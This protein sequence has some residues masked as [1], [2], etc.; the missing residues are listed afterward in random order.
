[1]RVVGSHASLEFRADAYNLFNLTNRTSAD[2]L[3]HCEAEGIGFIPWFPVASGALS[4]LD[5]PVGAVVAETGATPTQV[6]LAWLLHHS[7]V[8]L[9]I[10][11]TKSVDHVEE[12]CEAATLQ[13]SE[14]QVSV[15][16]A[17]H[18]AA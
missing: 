17:I 6:A 3:A 2:V 8:M 10:P 11:G 16:D 1:M 9:P 5:T 7:P 14:G 15:L 18:A 13:L 12:N 4:G